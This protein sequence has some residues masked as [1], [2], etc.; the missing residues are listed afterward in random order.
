MAN[1]GIGRRLAT[2]ARYLLQLASIVLE[3]AKQVLQPVT[4]TATT[5][6]G[7]VA[8]AAAVFATTAVVD[9]GTNKR[10][11]A[12]AADRPSVSGSPSP[13]FYEHRD[14]TDLL[15]VML[16]QVIAF[17]SSFQD[18]L[19][20]AGT[21]KSWRSAA[22]SFPS[23]YTSTFPPLHLKPDARY[24][25]R[26][27]DSATRILLSKCKWQLVDPSRTALPPR[28]LAP[29]NA[30]SS[31][32]YLGSSYGYLIFFD[33]THCLLVNAYTGTKTKSPKL[34][35]GNNFGNY[36]YGILTAPLNSSNSCL[37]LCSNTSMFQWKSGTPSWVEQPFASGGARILQIV[38]FKGQ[39]FAIDF[40]QRIH[41]MQ[42]LPQLAMHEVAAV[43]GEDMVIGLHFKPWL[44]VCGERLLLV[45]LSVVSDEL[46]G[47]HG[48]FQG[49]HLDLSTE[50]AKWVEIEKLENWTLFITFDRRNPTFSCMS[51]ERWGGKSNCIYVARP[52]EGSDE[53]WTAI[54]LGQ[55]VPST[56]RA[57]SS[58]L[59]RP[60]GDDGH[61]SQLENLWVLPSSVYD[62]GQ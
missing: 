14:W 60:P 51:P 1:A 40:L 38:F 20:F 11:V 10:K 6:D 57:I 30:P 3:L 54:E 23:I 48:K 16:H 2:M 61:Y 52:I 43:R 62:F 28:C 36:Y 33:Q 24:A 39:M 56:T 32:R 15:D 17:L 5:V 46:Y 49:F 27:Q 12:V 58:S 7:R 53:P 8:T 55:P 42:F 34:R 21:S 50:P 26:Q 4:A 45:D 31:A 59:M 37:L 41:I 18:F 35:P 29:R 13:P 25:R 22:S 44:V 47:I 9:T 19:A